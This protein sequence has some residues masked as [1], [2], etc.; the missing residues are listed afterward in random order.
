[1]VLLSQK[2]S[3]MGPARYIGVAMA[4]VFYVVRQNA[5]GTF[6]LGAP[7]K[8]FIE[9]DDISLAIAKFNEVAGDTKVYPEDFKKGK[10]F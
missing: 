2:M 7:N 6:L 8:V 1:M 10:Y 4:E 5:E 3:G 9:T